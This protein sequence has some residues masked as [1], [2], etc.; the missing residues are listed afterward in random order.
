[1]KKIKYD[2]LVNIKKIFTLMTYKTDEERHQ[3][4]LES[5]RKYR[6]TEKY[7]LAREKRK[8][9]ERENQRQRN[10]KIKQA[11][12]ILSKFEKGELISTS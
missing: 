7:L 2:G 6:M 5:Q 4:L 11:L 12:E 10:A 1:M 3:A 9:R 8:E